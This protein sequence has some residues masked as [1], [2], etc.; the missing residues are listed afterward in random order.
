[1]KL[2]DV[3]QYLIPLFLRMKCLLLIRLSDIEL[4][5]DGEAENE[6]QLICYNENEY[7]I[8]KRLFMYV[9]RLIIHKHIYEL[10]RST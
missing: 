2:F 8:I 7:I 9:L 4:K 5:R 1:M 10:S 6:C 3:N